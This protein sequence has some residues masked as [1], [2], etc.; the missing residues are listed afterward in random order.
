MSRRRTKTPRSRWVE[1]R[2]GYLFPVQVPGK[3]FRGKLLAAL[4]QAYDAGELDLTGGAA[5]LE[6]PAAFAALLDAEEFLRRFLLH[7]LPHRFVK[8][9]HFGL[10]AACHAT[11]TLEVA[12]TRILVAK[13]AGQRAVGGDEQSSEH[14]STLTTRRGEGW[15]S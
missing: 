8:I 13:D 12:R 4:R 1:G 14:Q 9:R 3:L 5:A 7:V 11:T 6:N 2:R 10:M 15:C